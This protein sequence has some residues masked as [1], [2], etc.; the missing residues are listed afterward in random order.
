MTQ[1]GGMGTLRTAMLAAALAGAAGM[2]PAAEEIYRV[3]TEH[4]RLFLNQRRL[5]LLQRE[6]E[7]RSLRWQQFEALIV[8]RASMPEP[9]FAAALYYRVSGDR[10]AGARAVGWALGPG[11]DL[12]QL[13]LVFDWCQE[14]LTTEQSSAL[15][16]RLER[17]IAQASADTRLS[18]VRSRLLAAVALAGH[19]RPSSGRVVE[20]AIKG[21][22]EGRIVPAL[23]EGRDPLPLDDHYALFEI[24]HAVRDNLVVDLRESVPRYFADLATYRLLA[25]YPAS[26]PAPENDYRIPASARAGEPDLARAA[27]ARAADLSIVAFDLNSPGGQVLQGWLM[28]DRFLLR[29][30]YGAPYEFLWANPYQPGLSYYHVPLVF[31][32]SR[33][34]RLFVRSSWDESAVWLG[35]FDGKV[36]LFREGRVVLPDPRTLSAPLDLTEAVVWFG[37]P[38][39]KFTV[40]A[41][42]GEQVFVLGLTPRRNYLVEVDDEEVREAQAD[43]GGILALDVPEGVETGVRVR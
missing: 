29:G 28:H 38:V 27:L 21:W 8:G 20:E 22:W 24:L 3:E 34:G 26:W 41:G 30:P 9:G 39:P 7:R 11:R 33:Y 6:R 5:R 19:A 1:S 23:K 43:G 37:P 32:D 14:V 10:A 2:A 40:A 16:G 25:Y 15:A 12:R 42:K 13:A 35:A 18:A 17:G 4:P 36:Q 31:H